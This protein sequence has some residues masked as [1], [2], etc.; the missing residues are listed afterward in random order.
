[1]PVLNSVLAV[2][3]IIDLVV[4][5]TEVLTEFQTLVRRA[6]AEGRDL[7]PDEVAGLVEL[8]NKAF[9]RVQNTA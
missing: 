9:D 7:T 3:A 4:S 5:V 6:Q 8:R 1:M 2:A